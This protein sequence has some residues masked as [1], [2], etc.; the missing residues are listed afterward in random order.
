[1]TLIPVAMG[2]FFPLDGFKMDPMFAA[3]AMAMS[4]ISVVCS[5]LFLRSY[6]PNIK[7]QVADKEVKSKFNSR[8]DDIMSNNESGVALNRANSTAGSEGAV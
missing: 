2:V 8:N 6:K 3:F 5:S 4:S 1:M 7:F